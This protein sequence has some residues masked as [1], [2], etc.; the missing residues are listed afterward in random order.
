MFLN[1]RNFHTMTLI[2]QTLC[3]QRSGPAAWRRLGLWLLGL[4]GL[5]VTTLSQAAT[6]GA[7]SSTASGLAPDQVLIQSVQQWVARQRSLPPE[8]VQ[9][10]PLDA[11]VRVQPCARALVLDH[12]FASHETVRVRCTEP[13]WQ[14]VHS[15][16]PMCQAACV[17][18]CV[19]ACVRVRVER[20]G[21]R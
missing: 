17:Y 7:A 15:R 11:R 9:L 13:A 4:C 8:Q 6:P 12:P 14:R 19:R 18:V 10:V 5:I 3:R 1:C 20:V 2:K 21:D 16:P